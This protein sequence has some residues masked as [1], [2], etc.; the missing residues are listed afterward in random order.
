MTWFALV[1]ALLIL[2]VPARI[3]SGCLHLSS[4]RSPRQPSVVAGCRMGDSRESWAVGAEPGVLAGMDPCGPWSRAG[5]ASFGCFT[6][7]FR[8]V[9]MGT[10][11]DDSVLLTEFLAWISWNI[12]V[13][14]CLTPPELLQP[15]REKSKCCGT[16]PWSGFV[17]FRSRRNAPG[18]VAWVAA[19]PAG[20]IAV[21]ALFRL[22]KG[23]GSGWEEQEGRC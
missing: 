18:H 8:H 4:P 3:C 13:V 6:V 16:G 23:D 15:F 10:L 22:S 17:D 1:T 5:W 21:T 12:V 11:D 20:A 14:C 7:V 9:W 19:L 2:V